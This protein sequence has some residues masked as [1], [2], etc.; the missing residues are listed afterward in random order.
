[1][2]KY[3]D[4]IGHQDVPHLQPPIV[5]EAERESILEGLLPHEREAREKG[6]P[7]LGSGAIYPVSE[8]ELFVRPFAIPDWWELGYALDPGW[9]YT[10]SL[11]G[12]RNPDTDQHY[13][14]AEY[15]GQRNEPVIH[16]AS[17]RAMLPWRNLEGC[18]DPAGDNVGSQ[19]DGSKLKQEYED[20]GLQLMN[21][22]NAVH[23]GLR[24]CLVL[25]QT[26]RLKVFTTCVQWQKEYRL[27]RRDE[28]GKIVKRFDHLMD[29]TRYLFNTPN[30]FQGKPI[31]RS[32][33]SP[34][35]EW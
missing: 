33:R 29:C 34:G 26:G 24:H 3:I 22:N 10:A 18:I 19:K 16:A 35:G 4:L 20:L 17:I 9:N 25:M 12:A 32:G 14:I 30:A 15:Y 8:S 1:M 6:R 21:A 27:Y 31:A 11:L 23:S 5:D 7:S 2:S 28:K 13:V